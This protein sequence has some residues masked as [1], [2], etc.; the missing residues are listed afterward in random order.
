[1]SSPRDQPAQKTMFSRPSS[2]TSREE[3]YVHHDSTPTRSAKSATAALRD[4]P[5]MTTLLAASAGSAAALTRRFDE[6][7]L[8]GRADKTKRTRGSAG[9]AEDCQ[10][11][12]NIDRDLP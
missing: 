6:S 1:M 5:L 12:I 7:S 9:S 11:H 3:W 8:A 2:L 10:V 4:R